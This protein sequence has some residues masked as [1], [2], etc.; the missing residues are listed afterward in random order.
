MYLV[1][2]N[3]F[4]EIFLKQEKSNE[5]KDFLNQNIQHLMVTDFTLHSIGIFEH[6]APLENFNF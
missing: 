5:C 3:I 2:T 6:N 4:L 1:D